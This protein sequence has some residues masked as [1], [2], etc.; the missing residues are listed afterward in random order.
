MSNLKFQRIKGKLISRDNK[1]V[2]RIIKFKQ[3]KK[4]V[5]LIVL[6]SLMQMLWAQKFE[7]APTRLDFE[8]EP[9]QNGQMMVNI[10]NHADTKKSYTVTLNDF[11][12]DSVGNMDYLD[13]GTTRKTLNDW[14]T[15]TPNFF[16]LQANESR[17]ISVTLRVPG[18]P[19]GNASRWGMLFIQEVAEQNTIIAADKNTKAGVTVNPA[20]GV[21]VL[22]AP[23]SYQNEAAE[24]SNFRFIEDDVK[25]GVDI[26]NTGDK[27]L[28]AKVYL[29]ISNLLTAEEK[30]MEPVNF[31]IVPGVKKTIELLLPGDMAKGEYTITGVLDYSPNKDLEGV[32]IDYK[33]D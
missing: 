18:G 21:Y 30:T 16:E 12:V 25:L 11:V 8:M 14:V 13:A 31:T 26:K 33:R 9:G 6:M 5:L 17:K 3:M 2:N 1:I 20:I 29:I 19:E 27:I 4:T 32:I 28:N 10:V 7:V 23:A 22:Q 15:V 24:I